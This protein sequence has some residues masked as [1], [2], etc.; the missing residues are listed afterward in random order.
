MTSR[1]LPGADRL[2]AVAAAVAAL[3]VLAAVALASA[4]VGAPTVMAATAAA[5]VALL[6]VCD[7]RAAL[8]ASALVYVLAEGD[9]RS[10]VSPFA[11]V[12]DQTPAF[13]TPAEL[14]LALAVAATALHV[15]RGRHPIR[16]PRP[17]TVPLALMAFAVTVGVAN[18]YL[19][20]SGGASQ[21]ISVVQSMA[22]LFLF[23]LLVVNVVRTRHELRRVVGAAGVLVVV[24]ALAGLSFVVLGLGAVDPGGDR[25]TYY[26]APA[27]WLMMTFTLAG[28]ATLIARVPLARWVTLALPLVSVT[29]LLSYRRSFWIAT[30]LGVLLIVPLAAG[31]TG[32]RLLVPA[33]LLIALAGVVVVSSGA[34]RGLEGSVAERANSL[35]PKKI[36]TNDEDRYRIAERRNVMEEIKRR[37][38]TGIGAGVDWKTRIPVPLELESGHTYV[39]L[40]LLWYWLKLGL[41]GVAAYGLV[42]GSAVMVGVRMWRRHP[43]PSVRVAAL[44]AGVGVLCLAVA[45]LT[46]TFVGPD[47]RTTAVIGMVIG[48]LAVARRHVQEGEAPGPPGSIPAP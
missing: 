33:L 22:P 27:N 12:Y 5:A 16:L 13:F 9:A 45:E 29:L 4:R 34:V 11:F 36:R 35:D 25:L 15:L 30:V 48:L 24:K 41:L 47:Q 20:G 14:V 46:A 26:Q 2:V 28:V 31:R 42:M 3:V 44:A 21:T 17:F 23:P 18:G 32:R 6:L 37:P 19:G 40:A 1:A 8:A 7:A 39:H 38:L 10:G 43:D